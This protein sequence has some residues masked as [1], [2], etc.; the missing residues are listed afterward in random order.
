MTRVATL[1]GAALALATVAGAVP[2]YADVES[3]I[4]AW[5]RGDYAAALKEWRPLAAKGDADAEFNLAQAY[6]LGRG[7]PQDMKLAENWYGKAA[8]QGHPGA[9]DNYGLALFQNGK[10]AEALPWI[11]KSAARGDPRAQ[12]VLGTAH[13]NGD[14]VAKDW[15][16]A[17][18]LMTRSAAAGFPKAG[19]SLTEMDR[20]IPLD[21]RQRG[22]VLARELETQTARGQL[23]PIGRRVATVDVQDTPPYPGPGTSYP[24][25]GARPAPRPSPP[26][27]VASPP[28]PAAVKTQPRPVPGRVPAPAPAAKGAWRIQ[29][30]AFG[31]AD[32]ANA[33]WKSLERKI[34]GLSAVQPYLVK[35]AG[36][37][38][39]Q[40]GP[41]A[42]RAAADR[43]CATLKAAGQACLTV[44][45]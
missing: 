31:Q 8:R 25:P 27:V 11:Q 4:A 34:S 32:N 40:A 1:F 43:Q 18:A 37:T 39:L 19:P 21:Q 36:V 6:R 12:Y 28:P 13:F 26:P 2:A 45:P 24:E 22:T 16:R 15:V 23:P 10:R 7:V 35:G 20:Y 38:R 41:F 33:L 17:Y 42:S 29:L 9:E 3:G 14:L 44:Q 5:E 30:G